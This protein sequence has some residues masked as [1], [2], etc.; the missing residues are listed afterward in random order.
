M[1]FMANLTFSAFLHICLRNF[2]NIYLVWLK[3]QSLKA[4]LTDERYSALQYAKTNPKKHNH[5]LFK[6]THIHTLW[7]ITWAEW[8]SLTLAA[9]HWTQGL[10]DAV[11]NPLFSRTICSW[12]SS[13]MLAE[14]FL[15]FLNMNI[16]WCFPYTPLGN[17]QSQNGRIS[18]LKDRW[19]CKCR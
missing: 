14:T 1:A 11:A 3:C 10:G 5:V 13:Q 12:I 15:A 18:L 16:S 7:W 6:S 19:K 8:K 9:A 4:K 17:P 2:E